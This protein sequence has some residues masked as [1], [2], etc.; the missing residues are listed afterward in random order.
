ME[1]IALQLTV[2]GSSHTLRMV[3][4]PRVPCTS[5][6]MIEAAGSLVPT[7]K[8]RTPQSFSFH[9]CGLWPQVRLAGSQQWGPAP[10]AW[11]I[12]ECGCRAWQRTRR[13]GWQE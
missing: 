10:L 11:E 1:V 6:L 3:A 12:P 5:G 2:A 13:T 8:A 9:Q 4:E 7:F